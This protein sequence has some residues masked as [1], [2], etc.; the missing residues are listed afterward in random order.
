MQQMLLAAFPDRT[1]ADRTFME[2]ESHGFD[3][4]DLSVISKADMATTGTVA[5]DTAAGA[6]G[7]MTTGGVLG[8]LAGFLAGAGIFPAIAG[9]LIGGPIAA[10]LGLTGV[11][12]ATLSGAVTGAAAGGLIG[13]LMN[14]GLSKTEAEYYHQT[15]DAGGLLL[16]IPVTAE[17]EDEARALLIA[18]NAQQIKLVSTSVDAY[19]AEAVERMNTRTVRKNAEKNTMAAERM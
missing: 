5:G 4:K 17:S 14:L 2:L 19:D 6:A 18:N 16:A 12:A 10:A 7:G 1:H 11:A 3:A 9:L 8:G 15:V 13:A